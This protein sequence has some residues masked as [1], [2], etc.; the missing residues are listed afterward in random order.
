MKVSIIV[1][2]YNVEKY[3]T[4]TLYGLSTQTLDDYEIIVVDDGFIDST[5]DI[6][7]EYRKNGRFK[8]IVK[9]MRIICCK[10]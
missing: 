8:V 2:V 3:L 6:L 5:P 4:E 1:A 9:K 7:E 10:R